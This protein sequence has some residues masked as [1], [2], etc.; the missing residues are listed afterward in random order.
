MAD[1]TVADASSAH[2]ENNNLTVDQVE[3]VDDVVMYIPD[4]YT[5][6][7]RFIRNEIR[8]N[9]KLCVTKTRKGLGL[10]REQDNRLALFL[11]ALNGVSMTKKLAADSHTISTFTAILR[12]NDFNFPQ[13]YLDMIDLLYKKWESENWGKGAEATDSDTDDTD[14]EPAATSSVTSGSEN[15]ITLMRRA[16]R[17]H[18][19][20]GADGIMRGIMIKQGKT[21]AYCL[22]TS[23]PKKGAKVYGHNGL[24]VGDWW[25]LQIAALRDGAHGAR[26]GGIAGNEAGGAYSIVVSGQYSDLDQDYGTTLYYSGSGSGDN[27]MDTP[28]NTRA[29]RCLA[30]SIRT[31]NLVRVLRAAGG[32]GSA[33][34]TGIRY[35]G[36]YTVEEKKTLENKYHGAYWQFKLVRQNDQPPMNFTRPTLGEQQSTEYIKAG[37]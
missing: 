13:K 18:R 7:E 31:G 23:W 28:P 32:S 35:D 33:P 11:H 26:I 34:S 22:D 10:T 14:D 20:Y 12:P 25:P 8:H 24:Q 37:Y 19:I 15:N 27:T 29:S 16:P 30:S 21:R 17:G 3:N 9:V 36:L 1:G 5:K 2:S 6:K 4:N